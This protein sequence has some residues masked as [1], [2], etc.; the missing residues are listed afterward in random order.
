M[1]GLGVSSKRPA[2]GSTTAVAASKQLPAAVVERV[3]AA[4]SEQAT[5][6]SS[7]ATALVDIGN[8]T[9]ANAAA[10]AGVQS[11]TRDVA[12][13]VEDLK[14]VVEILSAVVG[15]KAAV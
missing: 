14:Q 10:S 12:S 6:L 13:Q 9:Q 15:E 4:T 1:S 8:V 2:S 3:T 7:I 5:G 11:A